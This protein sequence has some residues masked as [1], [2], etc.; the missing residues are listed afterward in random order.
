VRKVITVILDGFGYREEAYGNAIK[1]ADTKNFDKLWNTYPH[2]TLHASEEYVGL[3]HGEF[4][5][6]EIGH[7][8]IGAGRKIKQHG[9]RMTEFF[10]ANP[11][12]NPKFKELIELAKT[13][14][15][16]IVGLYSDGNVHSNYNHFL[17][18]YELLK[19][20]NA[21]N[22]HFH[23]ITDGRDTKVNESVN[24]IQE[25]EE[26]IKDDPNT[27]IASICGRYYAMDRDTNY[28]RTKVYY[29]LITKGIG[30][31]AKNATNGIL[32]LYKKNITDEF[33][34]PIILNKDALIKDG[35]IVLWMNYRSDRG[36]QIIKSLT[37]K[38]FPDFPTYEFNNLTVYSF[39]NVDK[40]IKTITFLED[41]KINNALGLYLSNLGLTQTRIAETEKYAHVTYFFDGMYSGKIDKCSQVLVESPDVDTYDLKPEMSA[42]EVTKKAVN[43]MEKDIDFILVNYANPDMVGHTGNLEATI[44]AVT[45]VDICLERLYEVAKDNFYTLIILAD[46]GNADIMIDEYNTPVTT[47]TTSKVP[48]IITDTNVE[49]KKSGDLTNVA[50]TILEYMDIAL[51][52][53]MQET[54]TLF[55]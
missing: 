27:D 26:I 16:H 45:M 17:K 52:P 53:E 38:N 6:S 23:L 11:L 37:S 4:G 3:N 22:I 20:N 46:H 51:P 48:F 40:G 7:M 33:L 44:K 54:P 19:E 41:I 28:E 8:T 25:L 1:M 21:K 32:A 18:V 12:D 55:S 34:Y 47:H 10:K 13:K 2:T 24:Y 42:A 50:P 15:I 35:D 36:K 39:F 49:L 5:N 31:E 43:A 14:T 9:L 30:I 29:D